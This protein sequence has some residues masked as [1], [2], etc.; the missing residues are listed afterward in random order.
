MAKEE[1]ESQQREFQQQEQAHERSHN[2]RVADSLRA[3]GRGIR[4]LL[5]T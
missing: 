1:E 3:R 2:D 5:K 4:E